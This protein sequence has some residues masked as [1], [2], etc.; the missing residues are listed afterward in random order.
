MPSLRTSAQ[1]QEDCSQIWSLTLK[2]RDVFL[3]LIPS[4]SL[5]GMRTIQLEP[6]Q[7]SLHALP[8]T[9]DAPW[10][11]TSRKALEGTGA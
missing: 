6:R 7:L 9:L 4:L 3:I 5:L 8:V 1:N 11:N 2:S 10:Y